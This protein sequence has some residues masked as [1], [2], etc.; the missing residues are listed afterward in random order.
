MSGSV[1][2]KSYTEAAQKEKMPIEIINLFSFDGP[3]LRSPRPGVYLL[4]QSTTD[5]GPQLRSALK[6]AAQSIGIVLG[7]LY[8]I[9][10]ASSGVF[11]IEANFASPTPALGAAVTHYVIESLN[12]QEASNEEWDDDTRLWEL[13]RRR[14]VEALPMLALQLLAEANSRGIPAFVRSDDAIQIGYGSRGQKRE[15]TRLRQAAAAQTGGPFARPEIAESIF[16]EHLGTIPI[17]ACTGAFGA[18]QAATLIATDLQ[19]DRV[20]LALNANFDTVQALLSTPTVDYIVATL[21]PGSLAMR[22]LPFEQCA[23]SVIMS[24]PDTFPAGVNNDTELAR[25]YGLPMLVTARSG[26]VVLHADDPRIAA[27]ARY[28]PCP[29]VFISTIATNP[30]L[31]AHRAS[32]GAVLFP[33]DGMIIAAQGSNEQILGPDEGPPDALAGRLAALA[34]L[35]RY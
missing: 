8:V 22:G 9:A 10:R 34:I 1:A 6:D 17:I 21:D 19:T 12:A 32:G 15:F 13:Q 4:A 11:Q 28:A 25:V 23:G 29:V 2:R 14:R 7:Q 5:Q 3:N 31:A 30:I 26:R 16:W 27:L 35:N 18:D 24:L 20:E 33:R